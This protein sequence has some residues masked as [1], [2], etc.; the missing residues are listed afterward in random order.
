MVGPLNVADISVRIYNPDQTKFFSERRSEI[1][2]KVNIFYFLPVVLTQ[3]SGCE[4]GKFNTFSV[5]FFKNPTNAANCCQI[6]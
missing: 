1:Y 4:G 5:Q 6:I 3:Q 2:Y